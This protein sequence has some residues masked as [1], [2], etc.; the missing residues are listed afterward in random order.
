[1]ALNQLAKLYILSFISLIAVA[2]LLATRWFPQLENI[3]EKCWIDGEFTSNLKFL[4]GPQYTLT[5]N[6]PKK[7]FCLVTTWGVSHFI[8]YAVIGYMFP[9]FFWESF[10]IGVA[11]EGLEWATLECH[12]V[13]DIAWNT[14]GFVFG[15]WLRKLK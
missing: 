13:L 14:F 9:Q 12:D 6:E 4:R 10:A 11:F 1:M 8:M 5:G 7:E 15:A 2:I 3:I